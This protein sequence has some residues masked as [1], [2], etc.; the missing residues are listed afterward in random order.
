MQGINIL[1]VTFDR[2]QAPFIAIS[3]DLWVDWLRCRADEKKKMK[4]ESESVN[5]R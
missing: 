4:W 1:D 5:H 3:V 2:V